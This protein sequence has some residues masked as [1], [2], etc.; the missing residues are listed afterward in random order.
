MARKA[1]VFIILICSLHAGAQAPVS[2]SFGAGY[3]SPFGTVGIFVMGVDLSER[4]TYQLGP[5]INISYNGMG[6]TTGF[7]WAFVKAR[8]YSVSLNAD[9]QFLLS[10]NI[11]KLFDSDKRFSTYRTPNMHHIFAGA[12]FNVNMSNYVRN[13]KDDKFSLNVN[14]G[15]GL[16]GYQ[17]L[18]VAGE[19]HNQIRRNV[20]RQISSGIGFSVTYTAYLFN[21]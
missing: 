8:K 12:S 5:A 18:L 11:S 14:Y 21:N 4:V 10:R 20:S 13:L 2:A 9:Y 1:L 3:K 19:P 16:S 7:K 17:P 15:F 6:A